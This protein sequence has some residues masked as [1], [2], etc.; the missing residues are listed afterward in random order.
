MQE[1][2]SLVAMAALQCRAAELRIAGEWARAQ[3]ALSAATNR[4]AVL[5]REILPRVQTVR[6]I[7][8]AGYA[9]GKFLYLDFLEAQ[10]TLVGSRGEY[11]DALVTVHQELANLERMAGRALLDKQPK[12]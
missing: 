2:E 4:V 11:I 12:P 7:V 1:A 3:Q 9:Q 6:D 5:Q 8:Q 10:S